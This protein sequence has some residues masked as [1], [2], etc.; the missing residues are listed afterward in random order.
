M[1]RMTRWK[2]SVRDRGVLTAKE[3]LEIRRSGNHHEISAYLNK[4]SPK[5]R[6]TAR[7]IPCSK[8]A[9]SV[10]LLWVLK[11]PKRNLNC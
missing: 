1:R 11:L 2:T 6:L 3:N 9:S 8:T 10:T 5:V 7:R 4:I